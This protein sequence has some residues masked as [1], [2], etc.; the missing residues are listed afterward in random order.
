MS[1]N[2]YKNTM[3]K[4]LC[5]FITCQRGTSPPCCSSTPSWWPRQPAQFPPLLEYCLLDS[6][7]EPP[8]THTH[9][10]HTAKNYL[11]VQYNKSEF[12]CIQ[13]CVYVSILT[14][15]FLPVDYSS[16][17]QSNESLLVFLGHG[18]TEHLECAQFAF[19]HWQKTVQKQTIFNMQHYGN[20]VNIIAWN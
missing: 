10:W 3:C 16:S 13:M 12:L 18:G 2:T 20:R 11:L 1:Y 4:C 5:D 19:R 17:S 7:A 9:L 15:I 6:T 14:V 8:D